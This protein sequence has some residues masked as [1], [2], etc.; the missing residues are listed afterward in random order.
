MRVLASPKEEVDVYTRLE[1]AVYGSLIHAAAVSTPIVQADACA[2]RLFETPK[3]VPASYATLNG[4]SLNPDAVEA[5]KAWP[6]RE[7][8]VFEYVTNER[9]TDNAFGLQWVLDRAQNQSQDFLYPL[10]SY[11]TV[12]DAYCITFEVSGPAWG[13]IAYLRLAPNQPFKNRETQSLKQ[14]K[15]A[16]TRVIQT[17]Y[18]REIGIYLPHF[19]NRDGTHV[20]PSHMTTANLLAKLSHTERLILK[21]LR[22]DDT[23][24]QIAATIHRSPHTVHVHVKNI[25]R[26]LGVNSR[27]M[28]VSLFDQ[29]G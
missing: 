18:K 2:V 15:P 22:S 10:E 17:G 28:L 13:M 16:L 23:E 11:E 26:K 24:R 27:R 25:Y 7:N 29:A 6:T 21:Y 3:G 14:L 5:L 20:T 12:V 9:L 8:S 4:R 19:N 1:S